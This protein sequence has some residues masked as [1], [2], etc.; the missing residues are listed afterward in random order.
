MALSSSL[1]A[2]TVIYV[3]KNSRGGDGTTW[4]QAL[5]DLQSALSLASVPRS[6]ALQIWVAAGTYQPTALTTPGEPRSATFLLQNGVAIYGHF[7]GT[8]QTLA[9]RDFS[10][11]AGL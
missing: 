9:E 2:G 1:P 5:P 3:N 6:G 11:S 8:E 7:V 4:E 10:D